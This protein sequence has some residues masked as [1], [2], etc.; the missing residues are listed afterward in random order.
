MQ[1]V[2]ARSAHDE[3]EVVPHTQM[4]VRWIGRLLLSANSPLWPRAVGMSCVPVESVNPV[5]RSA[6]VE[7]E[8]A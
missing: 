3:C 2:T 4:M 7:C 6:P 5:D 8:S 1:V